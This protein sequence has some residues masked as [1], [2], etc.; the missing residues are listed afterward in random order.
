MTSHVYP[1][2]NITQ[3]VDPPPGTDH[4]DGPTHR[5]PSATLVRPPPPIPQ[6]INEET[7]PLVSPNTLRRATN[8]D[9]TYTIKVIFA[10]DT[11]TGKTCTL[12]SLQ[13]PMSHPGSNPGSNP[14]SHPHDNPICTVG[15]D[16]ATIRR[17]IDSICF[18]YNIWDTAGQEKY[19]A[20]TQSFFKNAGIAVLFFDLTSYASFQSLPGWL[21]DIHRNCHPEVIILLIG[22]KVDINHQR[23]IE[24]HEIDTFSQLHELIYI[25][26]SA[27]T[28][29]SVER[30]LY[31][32]AEILLDKI[33]IQHIPTNDIPGI[34][35]NEYIEIRTGK[36]SAI[37]SKCNIM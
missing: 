17:Q 6:S 2:K 7:V 15:V 35:I 25:E 4:I 9:T 19:R 27:H 26:I 14:G 30:I 23:E 34:R 3:K 1:S 10:G 13:Q 29:E 16:F 21:E 22:N 20:I 28:G 5:E 36:R 37:C 11:N 31:D 33:K 24:R 18:K 32:P 8:T 12:H